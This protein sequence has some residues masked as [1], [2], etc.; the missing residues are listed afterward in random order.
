MPAHLQFCQF[1][2]AIF[3]RLQDTAV[4]GYRSSTPTPDMNQLGSVKPYQLIKILTE[5]LYQNRVLAG[6]RHNQV[7]ILIYA[8]PY[9]TVAL[10]LRGC[11]MAAIGA[12]ECRNI[13]L[14]SILGRLSCSHAFQSFADNE[15]LGQN[16]CRQ[17][18]DTRADMRG[19]DDKMA[20]LQ[21]V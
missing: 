10:L 6:A 13:F 17:L 3:D 19:P 16:L 8:S 20:F 14:G 11:N 18:R 12:P 7:E 4:L 15:R 2:V 5:Q 9:R 21:A 1:S